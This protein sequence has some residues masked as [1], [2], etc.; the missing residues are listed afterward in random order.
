MA[1]RLAMLLSAL[2]LVPGAIRAQD[3]PK[4]SDDRWQIGLENGQYIWDIRLVRLQ[5]DT[6][7]FRQ[8]DTLGTVSVQQVGELRL[9]QKS[10]MR[11]GQGAAAGGAI[12]ALTGSDD[13]VYDMLTLDYP[14]R[15]RTIQQILLLHP[16]PSP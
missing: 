6:L 11:I 7:V 14:A 15:I 12:S 13:E 9:I 8:A 2:A 3:T 10:T 4:P 5:G 1:P 16:P